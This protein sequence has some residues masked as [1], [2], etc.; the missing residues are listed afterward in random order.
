MPER[1]CRPA[2]ALL[3]A[4]LAGCGPAVPPLPPIDTAQLPSGVFG[5]TDQDVPAA[6]YAQ[7]AL[8]DPSRTYG[9]PAAGAQAVLAMEYLAGELATSPRWARLDPGTQEQMV[10]GRIETRRAVGIAPAAPSQLVVDSLVAARNGLAS[11]DGAAA[12]RALSNPAF[13]QGGAH[14]V[15]ALGNL[16]YLQVASVAVQHAANEMSVPTTGPSSDQY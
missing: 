13:P 15:Q 12:E 5:P 11:G 4:I 16:P 10:L 8:S 2:A 3:A 1:G 6:L 7:N 14:T 9:N